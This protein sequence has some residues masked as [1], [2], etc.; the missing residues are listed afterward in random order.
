MNLESVINQFMTHVTH[1]PDLEF[2]QLPMIGHHCFMQ[3]PVH[4]SFGQ[5]KIDIGRASVLQYMARIIFDG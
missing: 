3:R 2:T 1:V 4:P 5:V